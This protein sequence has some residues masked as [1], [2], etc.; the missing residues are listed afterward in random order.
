M[1]ALRN[2]LGENEQSQAWLAREMKVSGPTV[3]DWLN[4]KKVPKVE[5]LI[6]LRTLTGISVDDLLRE[7]SVAA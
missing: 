1:E 3:S 4:S 7:H 6:K 2:W 5:H